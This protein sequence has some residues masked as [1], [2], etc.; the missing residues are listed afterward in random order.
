[1]RTTLG[2]EEYIPMPPPEVKQTNQVWAVCFRPD[3]EEV[4]MAVGDF[5][6]IYKVDDGVMVNK[7]KG[8]KDTVFCLAYSKDS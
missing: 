8:H 1:M 5:I 4:L 6:I 2:F 3:G 7:L